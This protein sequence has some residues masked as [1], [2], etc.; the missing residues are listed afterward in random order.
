MSF[1]TFGDAARFA[2]FGQDVGRLKSDLQRLSTE[3]GTGRKADTGTAVGGDF[4]GLAEVR[5]GMRLNDS[6]LSGLASAAVAAEARQ[7][8]LDRVA[9]ELDNAGPELL[10]VVANGR[11]TELS[12]RLADAPD[13]LEAA[14]SA[15]NLRLDGQSLFAGDAPDRPA[16]ADAASLLDALRPIASG[17]PDAATAIA[18]ID[19]WFQDAGGGFETAGYLGGDAGGGIVYLGEG[20]V[21][22]PGVSADEPGIR[23]AL[24]G[25]AM[26]ALAAEGSVPATEGAQAEMAE[27]AAGRMMAGEAGIVDIR[28]R[29]GVS[30]GRIE[31]ARVRAE[32]VRTGLDLEEVRLTGAD[33]F[34]TAT[35]IE[36]MRLKLESLYVLTAR[37]SGLTLTAYL[38]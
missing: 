28:A 13:R 20:S 8:A 30:E 6:F 2:T 15:L 33:P 25:L 4:S 18:G 14:V 35:E 29:L 36:A 31:E 27:A 9:R 21:T 34:E 7:S 24:A 38:R 10:A 12:L 3:L 11:S 16:L 26:A 37:L 17:A 23:T 32:A 22:R 1:V 5:R 19:A